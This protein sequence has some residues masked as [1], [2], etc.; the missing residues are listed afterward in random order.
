MTTIRVNQTN[1]NSLAPRA[2]RV[3]QSAD[4]TH[5]IRS[6]LPCHIASAACMFIGTIREELAWIDPSNA[7]SK[8]ICAAL[9]AGHIRITDVVVAGGSYGDVAVIRY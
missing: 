5:F 9:D 1:Q 6:N 2:S 3:C 4:G 8:A 7:Q